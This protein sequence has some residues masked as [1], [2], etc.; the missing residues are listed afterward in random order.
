MNRE[1]IPCGLSNSCVSGQLMCLS[2]FFAG[3]SRRSAGCF[4]SWNCTK[5]SH[6][7]HPFSADWQS[8]VQLLWCVIGSSWSMRR[9]RSWT[10]LQRSQRLAALTSVVDIVVVDM[11]PEPLKCRNFLQKCRYL[12]ILRTYKREGKSRDATTIRLPRMAI[13]RYLSAGGC[14]R[15]HSGGRNMTDRWRAHNLINHKKS[16]NVAHAILHHHPLLRMP[17]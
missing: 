1:L 5:A 10:C 8:A 17:K 9:S 2:K 14:W 13:S 3:E 11:I 6:S 16:K 4:I 15:G 7:L 12:F